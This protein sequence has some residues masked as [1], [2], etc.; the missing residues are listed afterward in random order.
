MVQE[1]SRNEVELFGAIG[2]HGAVSA[3]GVD[4]VQPRV[5]RDYPKG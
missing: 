5:A 2:V 4:G 1:E 3:V